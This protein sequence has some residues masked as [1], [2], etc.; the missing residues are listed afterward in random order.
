VDGLLKVTGQLKKFETDRVLDNL[1]LEREKG[2]TIKAKNASI[3]Y[4]NHKINI[5]IRQVIRTLEGK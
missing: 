2:I 5:M 3:F 1:E 4:K